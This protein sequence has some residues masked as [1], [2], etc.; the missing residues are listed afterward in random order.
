M[1]P[2]HLPRRTHEAYNALKRRI[3][4]L[5][6]PPGASFSEGELAAE[7]GFSKTPVR[8]ALARLRQE[9]LVEAVARSGYR[10]TPVTIKGARDQFELRALL[11]GEAA[12]TAARRGVDVDELAELERLCHASYRPDDQ[13]SISRFLEANTRLHVGL[14]VLGG[15]DA[16]AM[17]LQQVLEQL[18]RLF[19]VGLAMNARADELVHEHEELLAAVRSGDE[20]L[21]RRTATSQAQSSHRM[22]MEV[23]LSSD[24]VISANVVAAEP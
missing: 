15:N 4:D 11:E 20:D 6:L 19:N 5:T 8:E 10:V 17:M 9:R 22:V 2:E 12:A 24:S 21:A 16:L 23:L 1:P 14:A 18:E 13:S 7:L 3:I